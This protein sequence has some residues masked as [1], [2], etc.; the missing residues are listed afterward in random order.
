MKSRNFI[1]FLLAVIAFPFVETNANTAVD[2]VLNSLTLEEKI[3]QLITIRSD[4]QGDD[5]YFQ[6]IAASI[7]KY[8][9]GGVCFF[10]GTS[11]G[12]VK[13]NN[14]YQA[15]SKIPL[16]ICIDGEWGVSMRLTDIWAFPRAQTLG[17]I[18]DNCLIAEMGNVIA[19]QCN[20]LGV[21]VNFT[22]CVDVNSNPKNP[23]INTRSFGECRK[24]VANKGVAYMLGLQ[25]KNVMASAKHFPGHGDT[26]VDSH[27]DLPV[28]NH[29]FE[30]I[31]SMDL[32]PFKRMIEN[33]TKSVMIAHLNIPTLDN[34]RYPSS[35][36]KFIV[37]TL[38]KQRMG[39]EGLVFT[40]GLEMKGFTKF[41]SGGE[42]ELRALEAG[43]DVLLLP[44]NTEKTIKYIAQAVHSGR[45]SEKFINEKCRKILQAKYD[46]GILHQAPIVS[47]ENL[48]ADLNNP[49][50]T[51][52]NK[53]LYAN[54]ITVLENKNEIL[55][56][57][58]EKYNRVANINIG[59][60][61]PNLFQRTVSNYITSK[62][63]NYSRDFPESEINS[64]V[65]QVKDNDLLIVS[66]TNTN[67]F[68]GR[69]Y[70]VTPQTIRL[71]ERLATLEK[72]MILTIFASPYVLS[73][74]SQNLKI[75]GLLIAY[76]E[77]SAALE[78]AAHGMFG[79]NDLTGKLPITASEN[80][81]LFSGISLKKEQ[82][83]TDQIE[84]D[85]QTENIAIAE[86]VMIIEDEEKTIIEER[87]V[88][89]EELLIETDP[90][91]EEKIT[92]IKEVGDRR[93]SAIDEH[94]RRAIEDTVFPGCQVLVAKNGKIVYHKAFGTHTYD[95][96]IPVKLTDLYDVASITKIAATT[97]ALMKLY[98]EKKFN[99]DDKL[100]THLTYL[101]NTNKSD[102]TIRQ[103]L[104]HQ[105]GL[106]P[107]IWT[108]KTDSLF[109]PTQDSVFFIQVADSFYTSNAALN[110]VR[111]DVIE[112]PLLP[113][114]PYRYSDL[115][116]YLIAELVYRLSEKT[117]DEYTNENFYK[118]LGLSRT[119]FRPQEK[120]SLS[121]I[122][123]TENDT[124]FRMQ[125]I[126]GF[127]HDPTVAMLGGVGGSAGLFANA[128][129]LSVIMQMLLNRGEYEGTRY[130][131]EQTIGI[132]TQKILEGNRRGAGFDKPAIGSDK[133]PAAKSA[134]AKSFGHTGF[135]GT[136]AWADPEN[137]LVFI[138][139]SNRV[140]PTAANN[141][142]LQQSFRPE[143]QQMF[144]DILK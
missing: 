129:D 72:P 104:A 10:K 40:D 56:V 111:F 87:F 136:L 55:P 67:M 62:T 33:G 48:I 50:V 13:A 28:I 82:E 77:Q 119:T 24:N 81:P 39:F 66:I 32:Y 117:L 37:D 69:N 41:G 125:L 133:S 31:D 3:A 101:K 23:V 2:E 44:M 99:L 100:S 35:V 85:E 25:S 53:K 78:M 107:S 96:T 64:M 92:V 16:M 144:Y 20:R 137:K 15:T 51:D 18:Q 30:R 57:N 75:D 14:L 141:K 140:N 83:P 43:V 131:S 94:L 103:V 52:L 60:S 113:K 128:E 142:L 11:Q 36:S 7:K 59:N 123:P 97:L 76:Q 95:D 89:G 88:I 105:A 63:Y 86:N 91:I 120:F 29:S 42:M 12:L 21:H 34:S 127:V 126:H 65:Q 74:F 132:F 106:R 93:F 26:E 108:F 17:A 139:L 68:A 5:A 22:P 6:K 143:L 19:E 45:I 122:I 130:I 102:M 90:I 135:T 124:T 70:G 58:P 138:F 134:S 112:S 98:D 49:N 114:K 121:E 9:V 79:T 47:S 73:S 110:Q 84:Q 118:P 4:A 46:F 80:Y 1:V 54:A 61:S 71:I 116:F 109:S 8:G 38:L 27:D 115:S